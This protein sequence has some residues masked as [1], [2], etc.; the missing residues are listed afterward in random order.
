VL[1]GDGCI[2]KVVTGFNTTL[3]REETRAIHGKACYLS[4]VAGR[5]IPAKVCARLPAIMGLRWNVEQL[6][7]NT[8]FLCIGTNSGLDE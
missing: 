5:A 8:F 2:C 7:K 3:C 4:A 1:F 6:Y